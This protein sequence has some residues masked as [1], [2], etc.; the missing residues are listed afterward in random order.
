MINKALATGIVGFSL[1]ISCEKQPTGLMDKNQFL[2]LETSRN[3]LDFQGTPQ[4]V[5][6]R[7]MLMYSDSRSLV[8][9]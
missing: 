3:V 7:D 1:F 8:C 4:N 9:V 5:K 6:D 2:N